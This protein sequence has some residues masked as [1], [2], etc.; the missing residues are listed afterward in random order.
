MVALAQV[1]PLARF[2]PGMLVPV[3][4][5]RASFFGV[6]NSHICIYHCIFI[7]IYPRLVSERRFAMTNH[8]C[9]AAA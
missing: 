1:Y 4:E 2:V 6:G 3:N 7:I 8:L 5:A 9:D